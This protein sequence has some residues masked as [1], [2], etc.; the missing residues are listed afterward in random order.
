[1]VLIGISVLYYTR[2][3]RTHA[4]SSVPASDSSLVVSFSSG[5]L[6]SVAGLGSCAGSVAPLVSVG[7]GCSMGGGGVGA[8][9]L[10]TGFAF[11]RFMK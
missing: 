4:A 8:L 1:M 11:T 9:G 10:G 7:A 5:T 2:R 6:S 3:R